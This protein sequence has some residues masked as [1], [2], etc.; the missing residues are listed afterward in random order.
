MEKQ[1]SGCVDDTRR[2]QKITE[3]CGR[4]REYIKGSLMTYLDG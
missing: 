2:L 4:V 3:Y 1:I